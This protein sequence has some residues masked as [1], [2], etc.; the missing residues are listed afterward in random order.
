MKII[1]ICENFSAL[2]CLK[3][4]YEKNN[5]KNYTIFALEMHLS[6]GDIKNNHLGFLEKLYQKYYDYNYTYNYNDILKEISNNITNHT[7][8][9]IW[10]SKKNDDDYMLLLFLCNFLKDRIN[11]INIVFSSDYNELQYSINFLDYKKVN[12]VLKYEKKL[13]KDEIETYAKKWNKL[14]EINSELRTLENGEVKSKK[15]SDYY[16]IILSILKERK[17]CKIANLIG[18]CMVKNVL[19]DARDFVYLYLID[20]LIDLN[21]IK[22]IEKGA[23]HFVDTIALTENK[24]EEKKYE[25]NNI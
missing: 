6:I 16:N 23:R 13:S 4:Y 18:E 17:S 22:I 20:Q 15:Y 19:N 9:R 10:S 7:V 2:G 14:V 24:M 3:Q 5:I 21:K 1:D 11:T 12:D 25:Y 8:I